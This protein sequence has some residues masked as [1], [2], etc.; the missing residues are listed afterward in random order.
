[1]SEKLNFGFDI[2]K[3]ELESRI[4]YNT[5]IIPGYNIVPLKHLVNIDKLVALKKEEVEAY[6]R[7]IPLEKDKGF[8]P[9]KDAEI[10][11]HQSG[12]HG[13]HV[14]QTFI[15][16]SKL[17]SL[18]EGLDDLYMDHAFPCLAQR[19]THYAFGEDASGRKVVGIY[20]PPLVEV[21][22][23]GYIAL[24]LDGNHRMALG[25]VGAS[26]ETLLIK[27]S[28]GRPPYSGIPWHRNFVDEKPPIVERYI[29]LDMDWFRDFGHIGLDG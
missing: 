10:C 19:T 23:G 12:P 16:R 13:L 27:K 18:L 9:F 7:H 20:F 17:V 3:D 29:D 11:R 25:G 14:P 15:L 21:I 4:H 5:Q 26:F 24:L 6:L 8:F 22:D 1:M 2:P 28:T